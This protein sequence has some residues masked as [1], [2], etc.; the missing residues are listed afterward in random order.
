MIPS[1]PSTPNLTPALNQYPTILDLLSQRAAQQPQDLAYTFLKGGEIKDSETS[2]L[3]YQSLDQQARTIAQWLEAQTEPGARVLL[4][5][6]YEAGL[7]FISAFLGCL[8]AGRVAVSG[9][10]PRN[11]SGWN[12]LAA[13]LSNAEATAIC[14]TQALL[15][16]LKAQLTAP[17]LVW[18]ATNQLLPTAWTPGPISPDQLA[19]LQYTS[20]STG[21]PKG[22]MITHSSLM[23]NQRL[24][25]LAFGH[26]HQSVGVG[27][28][29]LFHD[30][31]LIGNVLQ[32]L[33]VGAPCILMSPID[34]VQ[35]P[36]R[37]LQAISHY[38]ATTSG[39]PNFAYNLL[40]RKVTAE[41]LAQLDLSCW[42]V[43][44]TGA[45]PV[46][47]ETL[48]R[49]SQTFAPCGFRREAFY[50]CYGMAEATLF[51]TGGQKLTAP[52][53]LQVDQVALDQNRIVP[54]QPGETESG[55]ALVSCGQ[56]WLDTTITI[57]DPQTQQPCAPNQIGEIWVTGSGLGQGYWQQPHQ[58]ERTFQATLANPPIHLT[59]PQQQAPPHPPNCSA[60]A[61][62]HSSTPHLRTNDLGF[63]H[64]NELYITGRLHDLL[65]FWGFN[66]YPQHLEQ[67]VEACHPGFR[68]SS[69][70]A[71]AVKIEGEERLVIVQEIERQYRNKL[72]VA[73][74]AEQVRWRLF[75]EHF[76]NLFSLAL[77]KPGSLPKTSSGKVQRSACR[78]QFLANQ[79][80]ILSQWQLPVDSPND[81]NAI[82]ERYLNP[83]THLK[84]Y[85]DLTKGKI[86]RW[87]NAL[88]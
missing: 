52:T 46:R 76:V 24:L 11:Q 28:L 57:V 17:Q 27:W 51:I 78:S 3:T 53:V 44:F 79:L 34:F 49:F 1:Q 4:V 60:A 6:P 29:P 81:P 31:G 74:V 15:T 42:E 35:K 19:F 85:S 86:Q 25:Q 22:V 68:P 40:C 73:E 5:Y 83:A 39:A 82:M 71:F 56:G 84:R 9:H 70:A 61:S 20:G 14:S 38:R 54:I 37:W 63:L 26:T 10:P 87:L 16:K 36:I 8:Y 59:A 48:E 58:T 7:E 62:Y 13:R 32:A 69:N 77:L 45:E 50:P 30:M 43:A 67:T 12:E 23:Q 55:R 41:Q 75:E 33:Y 88:T 72:T 47:V 18:C 66:H 80:D 64:Q 2:T 65:I 21:Q